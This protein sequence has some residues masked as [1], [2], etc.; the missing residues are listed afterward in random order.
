MSKAD[1][2][3]HEEDNPFVGLGAWK[4]RRIRTCATPLR[5]F[6]AQIWP[7]TGRC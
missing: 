4:V 6:Q 5:A 1:Q 2:T 3:A 7:W